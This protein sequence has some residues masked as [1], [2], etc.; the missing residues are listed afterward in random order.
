M[1]VWNGTICQIWSVLSFRCQ[2]T[3]IIN[4]YD[5]VGDAGDSLTVHNG[6]KF[7]TSD[8]KDCTCAKM[9]TRMGTDKHYEYYRR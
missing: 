6:R 5:Y 7:S 9:G 8:K 2:K 3:V 1:H 4:V